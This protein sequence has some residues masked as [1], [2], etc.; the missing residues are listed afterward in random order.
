MTNALLLFLAEIEPGKTYPTRL[1]FD[2]HHRLMG[3]C[4]T[5]RLAFAREHDID[6]ENGAMTVEEFVQLTGNAYGGDI[7]RRVAK[8]YTHTANSVKGGR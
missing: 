7:I 8:H 6:L 3:S 5:G 4:E 1:F 2:W